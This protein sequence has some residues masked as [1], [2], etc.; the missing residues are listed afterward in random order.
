M[1]GDTYQHKDDKRWE[2]IFGENFE[3]YNGKNGIGKI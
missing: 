3:E 2:R 1:K